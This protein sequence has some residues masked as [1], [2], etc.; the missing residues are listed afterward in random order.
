MILFP[1]IRSRG[2]SP[3]LRIME[4]IKMWKRGTISVLSIIIML[5][6]F[7]IA[8]AF[9]VVEPQRIL[10]EEGWQEVY[11]IFPVEE[12][13]LKDLKSELGKVDIIEV[14]FAFWCSDSKR[15][16]P[17]FLKIMDMAEMDLQNVTFYEV[18]RKSS[19][20]QKYY[21]EE[22]EVTRIPTFILFQNG[23]ELGRIVESP[24]VGMAEDLIEILKE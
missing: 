10:S 15:E 8:L 11:D 9:P 3:D 7:S 18:E 4:V 16:L 24:K 1:E 17:H 19:D 6:F 14:Y 12:N 22:K 23:K 21:F 20:D 5:L 2:N 13:L